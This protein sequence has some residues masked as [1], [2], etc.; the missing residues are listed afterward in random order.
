MPSG[1]IQ[2]F[3]NG[4]KGR[5]EYHVQKE[6]ISAGGD[7]VERCTKNCIIQ[8]VTTSNHMKRSR[9][10]KGGHGGIDAVM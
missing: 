6:H 4:S 3:H 10:I 5:I 8:I 1:R 9:N 2:C 7:K